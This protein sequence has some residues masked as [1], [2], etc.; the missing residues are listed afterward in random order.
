MFYPSDLNQL[1]ENIHEREDIRPVTYTRKKYED[2]LN[3]GWVLALI[4]GLLTMEWFLR[5]RAGSY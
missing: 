5:K 2:L 4:I 1:S 3:K